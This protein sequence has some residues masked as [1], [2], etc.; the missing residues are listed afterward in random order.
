M[1]SNN[2]KPQNI[3]PDETII[4]L[5]WQREERAIVATDQKYGKY[6]FKIAYNIIANRLDCEECLNDT[7]LNTW[8]AIPP[9]RPTAFSLFLTKITRNLALGKFRLNHAS[10]R[11]PSELVMSLEELDEC[12]LCTKS[13]EEEYLLQ[14]MRRV[15]N[16][17][18]RTLTDR[19][20]YIFI[21]RYYYSDKV[22]DIARMLEMSEA[23]VRRELAII[24]TG[25]KERLVKEGY[26]YEI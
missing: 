24:R 3:L 26:D 22:K 15:L 6:L 17:F 5:Y 8:N 7:Y 2:S 1:K 23:T 9:K 11:I 16:E 19:Q 14:D 21:W 10:K 12:L 4:D 18:L 25:L 13:L 20:M